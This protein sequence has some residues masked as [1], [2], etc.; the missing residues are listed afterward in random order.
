[1]QGGSRVEFV[2]AAPI[3]NVPRDVMSSNFEEWM[4]MKAD[5]VSIRFF[6]LWFNSLIYVL[7][8]TNQT[9]PFVFL[10][11]INASNSG[12]FAPIDSFHDTPLL[13]NNIENSINFQ[14]ASRTLDGCVKIW[15]AG[16]SPKQTMLFGFRTLSSE[17]DD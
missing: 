7:L 11:K 16:S 12:N 9:D 15:S 17:K 2:P 5:N 4:K 10:Q 13:R 6:A 8:A 3:I 14:R 1:M